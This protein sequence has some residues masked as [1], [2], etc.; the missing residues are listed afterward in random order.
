[1]LLFDN[2]VFRHWAFEPSFCAQ[3]ARD[4]IT[5]KASRTRSPKFNWWLRPSP[6]SLSSCYHKLVF[7]A[8]SLAPPRLQQVLAPSRYP[9]L[10]M[11]PGG[12]FH[13]TFRCEKSPAV[14]FQMTIW[15]PS[16][17][18]FS[19]RVWAF[20]LFFRTT[21]APSG[22]LIVVRIGS[23]PFYTPTMVFSYSS[24]IFPLLGSPVDPLAPIFFYTLAV[25]RYSTL[26]FFI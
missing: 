23:S 25:P 14:F 19:I 5:R 9:P 7:C 18:L 10:V 21:A 6:P 16:E 17:P 15:H 24:G 20:V 3:V 2:G 26:S 12:S 13:L 1:M 8:A 11:K 4:P 22:S